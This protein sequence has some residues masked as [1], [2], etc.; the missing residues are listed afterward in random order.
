MDYKIIPLN[1]GTITLDQG[2]YCTLGRGIGTKVDTPST[3]W[4]ITD[5][6]E[7]FLVDTGMCDTERAN[8]WH[9]EGFQ[10][11]GGRIDEQLMSRAGIRP[12]QISAVFFTHLHWDHCS[13][14]KLFEKARYYVQSRELEFALNPTLPP[15][16]RSYE[17]SILGI[18]APFTGCSFI[19][20]EGEYV[21]Q[22]RDHLLPNA[23][24]L[25][26]SP[27]RRRPDGE[28]HR[29]DRRG[30]GI[31]RGEHAGRPG[32]RSSNSS[33]SG[34]TPTISRCG[35]VSRRS[36]GAPIW[37]S[38]GT[39]PGC[40]T[41]NLTPD[42]SGM[43]K[44]ALI[45]VTLDTKGSEALFLKKV[46][47][48]QGIAVL[49]MDAG[50]FPRRTARVISEGTRS[51]AGAL[52]GGRSV[53]ELVAAEDRGE[54]I[55]TMMNGAAALTRSLYD[56]GKIQGVLSLGGAQGTLIGT[57][58]MRGLPVGV[59]K[60]MVST[61]ASGSRPFERYVG[62]SDVTLIH[63]VVDFFGLNPILKRI[64]TNAAGAT[65]GMM[66]AGT[67]RKG[68]TTPGCRDDLRDDDP[69]RDAD[70]CPFEEGGL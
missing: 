32:T 46:L 30:C 52:A 47:E 33:P 51:P 59:P 56:G 43:K 2:A 11:K 25:R 38:R 20:V 70:R 50:I 65:A 37:C 48:R 28:R 8:K 40:S 22:R 21:Y 64:L 69:D 53:E 61:M 45:I 3:A 16:Y 54:A 9:H 67:V 35:T 44:T 12:D 19:T 31:R 42:G 7:H 39:T 41:D 15:Y 63:S 29:R 55:R 14:M 66:T 68:T 24:P 23:G 1:T 36:S 5:G 13:N 17:A 6:T 34:G 18:E 10:P 57:T 49:I 58:A 4:C 26:G 62:T 60:V 27:V